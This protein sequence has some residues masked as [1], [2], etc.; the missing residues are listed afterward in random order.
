MIEQKRGF[1]K[2]ISEFFYEYKNRFVQIQ[3]YIGMPGKVGYSAK[4]N[5]QDVISN[6]Q[7]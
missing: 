4:L 6:L 7:V 3:P 5:R 2:Q 1:D